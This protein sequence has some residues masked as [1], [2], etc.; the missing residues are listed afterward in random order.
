MRILNHD[1][2]YSILDHVYAK[3]HRELWFEMRISNHVSDVFWSYASQITILDVFWRTHGQ[4]T[5]FWIV[6]QDAHLESRFKSR[7]KIHTLP[8]CENSLNQSQISTHKVSN[9]CFVQTENTQCSPSLV[10]SPLIPY[11]DTSFLQSFEKCSILTPDMY[12]KP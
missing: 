6:I 8:L 12:E 7:F 11:K 2:K 4:N 5:V 9:G 10:N 3:K 1:S